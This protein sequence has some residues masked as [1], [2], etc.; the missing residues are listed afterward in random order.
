MDSKEAFPIAAQ[1]VFADV[2]LGRDQTGWRWMLRTLWRRKWAILLPALAL[3]VLAA[4]VVARIPPTYQGR[5]EVFVDPR[6]AAAGDPHAAS[7]GSPD[8]QTLASQVRVLQSRNLAYKAVEALELDEDPE[9]NT[10]LRPPGPLERAE[11]W[12]RA[13]LASAGAPSATPDSAT[14][15]E[16]AVVAAGIVDRFLA[17]LHVELLPESRVLAVTFESHSP[18]RAA[19]AANKLAEMYI[20]D[21]LDAKYDAT[22]RA[23]SWLTD[24]IAELRRSVASAEQAVEK[25]RSQS[26]LLQGTGGT[27]ATQ[28]ASD[29]SA[30]LLVVRNARA[31]AEQRLAKVRQAVQ[32]GGAGGGDAGRSSALQ[33]LLDQQTQVKRKL[34]DLAKEFGDRHPQMIAA[35]AELADIETKLQRERDRTVNTLESEVGAARAREASLA[36]SLEQLRGKLGQSANA[37]IQLRSL[38]RDAEASRSMLET[39]L[40]RFEQ[41]TAQLDTS[42][43]EMDARIISRADV[44]AAPT[45]PPAT[46][47]IVLT[48]CVAAL[49]AALL[50]FAL[51]QLD[52]GFRSGEQIE[53]ATGLRSLGLVPAIGSDGKG[54]ASHLLRHP[55]SMFGESIRSLYTGIL[56][57]PDV[58]PP[59]KLL[60][61]SS[62]PKEGKTTISVCLGRMRALAGHSTVIVEADL[63]RPSMH[64]ALGVGRGPGLTEVV[65]G[66]KALDEVLQRD[67][68]SGAHF[69]LAG[70]LAPDPT[71]ILSSAK[72]TQVLDELAR[73]FELV[74]VD[75]PPL[76]AV[77][78]S[79][80]LAKQVDAAVLVVRW[81]RTPRDVVGLA[82]K[83][84]REA[85]GD[86]TGVVLSM[87]DPKKHA[88]YG[89]GDSAYYYG[90]VRRYYTS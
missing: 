33:Q 71:E 8:A 24:K 43:N 58:G 19:Q 75:S 60:V 50:V 69:L 82:V 9:F 88:Q 10:A 59:R 4:L 45:F 83:Q 68:D 85:R 26:G 13:Q 76:V 38:E 7:G 40:A 20:L 53:K 64:R 66:E 52:R 74:V 34:A 55:S 15:P 1:R 5:A 3:A 17:A 21:Q 65:L 67:P 47:I 56:L 79:R 70:K 29:L 6:Q 90:P 63:R 28:Q 54:P 18:E 44:P 89:F 14:T 84:L 61:T 77:S 73:R 51:E 80:L 2:G 72:M 37:E 12:V 31:E 25:F 22:Q 39:F 35:R 36:R 46:R 49:L 11:T 30:Q 57:S 86:I 81:A 78:D 27:M 62:Q 32:T 23:T 16:P 87:V 42:I 48:F 41:A